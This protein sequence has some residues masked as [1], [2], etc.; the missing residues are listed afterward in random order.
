MPSGETA[1][2]QMH[3][4]LV[5]RFG[6]DYERDGMV[7]GRRALLGAQEAGF[8]AAWAVPPEGL[9]PARGARSRNLGPGDL[10]R[11]SGPRL[12]PTF[13]DSG[14]WK[15][16]VSRLLGLTSCSIETLIQ[17]RQRELMLCADSYLN[18]SIGESV[19]LV[20]G[21]NQ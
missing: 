21:K 6:P 19:C 9:D 13:W 16:L 7:E 1:Q 4:P 2:F 11:R 20:C 10:G 14:V 8:G 12:E 3:S 18:Q 15:S 17:W 5:S